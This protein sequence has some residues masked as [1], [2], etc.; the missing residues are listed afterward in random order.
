MAAYSFIA[1]IYNPNSTGPSR[2][3]AEELA[4]FVRKSIP[5]QKLELIATKRASHGEELAYE[6]AMKHKKP[7]IISS[8]GDGGYNEVINGA[9]RAKEKGYDAICAVL[10]S[11]NANDHSRTLQGQ[12]LAKA[13]TKQKISHID[14]LHADIKSKGKTYKRYAHS[15]IG[16]GLTPVIA[17]ELNRHTLSAFKEQ[18]I[19]LKTFYKLRPFKIEVDG[20]RITLDSLIFSNINQMAKVLTLSSKSSVK[21]G[22][23]E[24]TFFP[25]AHKLKLI[26]KLAMA[27][28]SHSRPQQRTDRYEFVSIRKMP[29]QLDGEVT[30]LPA[31][32]TVE[33]TVAKQALNTLL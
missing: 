3:N 1:I 18:W 25:H 27:V 28:F 11:G 6:L 21:D 20:K 7:L 9:M 8:S 17:T 31:R 12:S 22:K 33:I 24:V 13:V 4:G 14:L 23:F 30:D 32:A 10:P 5:K 29:M 16:L 26:A 15:Y 19:V 2:K